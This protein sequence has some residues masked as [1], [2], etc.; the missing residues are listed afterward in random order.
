M[1][2][3]PLLVGYVCF[4]EDAFERFTGRLAFGFESFA[5]ETVDAGSVIK[6]SYRSAL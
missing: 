3:A 2:K 6:P 5:Q 4:Y 1:T